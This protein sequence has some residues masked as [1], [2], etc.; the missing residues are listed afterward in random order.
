MFLFRSEI[1]LI[2]YKVVLPDG[3][4]QIV[5]YHA[6]H[7]KGYFAEVK[8]ENQPNISETDKSSYSLGCALLQKVKFLSFY[9][10]FVIPHSIKSIFYKKVLKNSSP[11]QNL[12]KLPPLFR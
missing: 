10:C 1:Q 2:E 3:R 12:Q 4:L 6:D 11:P 5:T 9:S 8:Y 7:E